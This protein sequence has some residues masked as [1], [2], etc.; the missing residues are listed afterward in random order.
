MQ[1]VSDE[2]YDDGFTG[3]ATYANDTA[4][5]DERN[6][7]ITKSKQKRAVQ[8]FRRLVQI[9]YGGNR[10]AHATTRSPLRDCFNQPAGL[11][12]SDCIR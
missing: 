3:P 10:A 4:D 6:P 5:M 1:N 9:I 12:D 8:G 2:M 11:R 7:I